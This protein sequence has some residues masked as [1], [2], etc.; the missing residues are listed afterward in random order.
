MSTLDQAMNYLAGLDLVLRTGTITKASGWSTGVNWVKRKFGI[1]EFYYE[2]N[3][4]TLPSSGWFTVGTLPSGFRPNSY[5]DMINLDNQK[6]TDC[7]VK[8]TSTGA[9]QIYRTSSMSN[10][11]RLHGMFSVWG[12]GN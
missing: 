7:C 9:I 1:V 4:G 2:C 3:G 10:N 11:F 5:F 6:S 8:V 12:G